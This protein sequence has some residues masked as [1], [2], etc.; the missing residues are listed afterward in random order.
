M[1]AVKIFYTP[2][3]CNLLIYSASELSLVC[4]SFWGLGAI[5]AASQVG[6][7][8]GGAI[9]QQ[10]FLE[11][12]GAIIL[13]LLL[14][15]FH[16]C[17]AALTNMGPGS[18]AGLILNL[19]FLLLFTGKFFTANNL[20]LL[21]ILFEL[22]LLPIF[23]IVIGWGYQVE[24]AKAST[25]IVLYTMAGSLPLLLL[26]GLTGLNR[27]LS[28]AQLCAGPTG[29]GTGLLVL[30]I[31]AFLVKLPMVGVHIWLPKAHVEAPVVG[32]MFLAAVLLKLGG[33]G[34]LLFRGLFTATSIVL[35][36]IRVRAVGAIGVAILCCQTLDLKVLI[37][38]T[39][40]GHMAFVVI[41]VALG[42]HL[43]ATVGALVLLR[44]GF[45]SSL[46]FFIAYIL[47]KLTGSRRLLINKALIRA[48]G[49]LIGLWV[50]MVLALIGCP[51]ALN[52]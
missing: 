48:A 11:P 29:L 39:S 38:F 20:S 5:G 18:G 17:L 21:Y 30:P 6:L 3:L 34:L 14:L 45:R 8:G 24:R 50:F 42:T 28:V 37:A 13:L 9:G 23:F 46:G 33:F 27:P 2:L 10:T 15:N 32:S 25:A 26:V 1:N 7:I 36:L 40:V 47:Y 22:R 19:F 16:A 12:L 35:L 49:L 44:H 4:T 51:P 31:V 43:R 52:V 41:G